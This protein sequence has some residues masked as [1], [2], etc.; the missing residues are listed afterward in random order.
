MAYI[1]P[2]VA[3]SSAT[4]F[5]LRYSFLFVLCP[6]FCPARIPSLYGAYG[7]KNMKG[8]QTRIYDDIRGSALSMEPIFVMEKASEWRKGLRAFDEDVG[9]ALP[10]SVHK[11]SKHQTEN[12]VKTEVWLSLKPSEGRQIRFSYCL[13]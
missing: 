10:V 8:C 3:L 7:A 2:S 5:V 6:V 4:N 12:A 11:L 13:P 1:N 9:G